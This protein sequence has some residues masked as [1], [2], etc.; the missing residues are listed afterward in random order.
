[1][2]SPQRRVSGLREH[3]LDRHE[4]LHEKRVREVVDHHADRGAAPAAQ[5]C[6][7][8]VVDISEALSRLAHLF[9]SLRLDFRALLEHQR[10]SRFRHAGTFGNVLDGRACFH[11]ALHNWNDPKNN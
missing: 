11:I 3:A 1:M 9:G 7:S 5:I 6:C 10:D 2:M 8:A 4:Q